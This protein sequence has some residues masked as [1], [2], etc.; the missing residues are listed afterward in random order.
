MKGM[1]IILTLADSE[2]ELEYDIKVVLC[3]LVRL[4]WFTIGI[5]LLCVQS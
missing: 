3:Q 1:N 5:E 4:F 2:A